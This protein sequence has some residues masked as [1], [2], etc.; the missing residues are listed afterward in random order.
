[1][2]VLPGPGDLQHDA[3]GAAF[4]LLEDHLVG[5]AGVG[6]GDALVDLP[7]EVRRPAAC[8][9]R[10]NGAAPGTAACAPGNASA[11]V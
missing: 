3:V 5:G 4:Q 2:P 1:M 7:A 11:R 10:V 9:P 6:L 8:V